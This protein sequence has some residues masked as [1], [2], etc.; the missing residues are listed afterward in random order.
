MPK[1][2]TTIALKA[3]KW[4]NL[5]FTG[6]LSESFAEWEG[7]IARPAET[8]LPRSGENAEKQKLVVSW[9]VKVCKGDVKR[10][11]AIRPN[12]AM[13]SWRGAL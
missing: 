9:I 1:A 2:K 8:I 12:W 3:A 7:R 5:S 10:C 6:S 13:R 4:S 11:A